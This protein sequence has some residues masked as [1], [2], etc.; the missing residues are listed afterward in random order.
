MDVDDRPF[1][2]AVGIPSCLSYGMLDEPFI[3]R[4]RF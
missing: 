4:R 3:L 1:D 2:F